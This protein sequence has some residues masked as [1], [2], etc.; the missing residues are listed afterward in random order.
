[1][2]NLRVS[3]CLWY[4]KIVKN[5]ILI[6]LKLFKFL[7]FFLDSS[8]SRFSGPLRQVFVNPYTNSTKYE[9]YDNNLYNSFHFIK[10]PL[11]RILYNHFIL[12]QRLITT[13]I[14]VLS[15]LVSFLRQ[16]RQ[17]IQIISFFS[18]VSSLAGN[19]NTS[20]F[21]ATFTS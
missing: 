20:F 4:V 6:R 21:R 7:N 3:P 15:K 18:K 16:A 14:S 12:S 5:L 9:E 19:F 2:V 13:F 8:F 11:L 17:S 1:M 10:A